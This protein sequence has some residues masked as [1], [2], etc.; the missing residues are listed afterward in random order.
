[1]LFLL[2][3]NI[4]VITKILIQDRKLRLKECVYFICTGLSID[5]I[6]TVSLV[7]LNRDQLL[8]EL[9]IIHL[10]QYPLLIHFIDAL[11]LLLLFLYIHKGKKKYPVKKSIILMLTVMLIASVIDH[12][13]AAILM[14]LGFSPDSMVTL[15]V[16]L[17]AVFTSS[18]LFTALLVKFTTNLRKTI[19]Q[20]QPIQTT[21]L[22]MLTFLFISFQASTIAGH[23]LV[24]PGYTASVILINSIFF[25]LFTTIAFISFV[26]LAKSLEAKYETQAKEAEQ[27]SLERYTTELEHNQTAIRKFKHDYQNI[28][29]SIDAFLHDDDLSGLKE[30]YATHITSASHAII[31]HDIAL[32]GLSRIKIKALKGILA[33]KL[34]LAQNLGIDTTFEADEEVSHIP[35]D[36]VILVRML[37]IILD[38][39]IEAL[40]EIDDGKLSAGCFKREANVVF[41]VQN[42]C[43]AN[44][45][46]L[47]QIFQTGFSTKGENRGLGLANL[48]ELANSCTNVTLETRIEDNHFIQKL[49]ISTYNSANI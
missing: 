26:M 49:I 10:D 45:P 24:Y 3:I 38:N 48:S 12:A 7:T 2:L 19:N 30:Y 28:L 31:N 35:I 33:A 27:Q 17:A 47:R 11:I 1:M 41:I 4:F 25:I 46:N 21:S 8:N 20:S 44:M 23:H 22:L 29:L 6:A 32:E 18:I 43:S 36:P 14:S 9:L 15:L 42:T 34:M 13:V 39:A 37:G 16:T 40:T 5:I